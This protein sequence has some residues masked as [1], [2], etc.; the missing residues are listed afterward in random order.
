MGRV[1]PR[2]L[3]G[4]LAISLAATTTAIAEDGPTRFQ[5]RGEIQPQARSDEGRFALGAELKVV[6]EQ[7]S[8]D[9]RFVI[10]AINT[11][12]AGCDPLLDLFANGFEGT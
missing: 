5:V 7:A 8:A 2:C 11:P 10:K 3:I 12:E 6:P 4:L 9:G 1:A